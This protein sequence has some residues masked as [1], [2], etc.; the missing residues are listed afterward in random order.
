MEPHSPDQSV[1]LTLDHSCSLK[2]DDSGLE[3]RCEDDSKALQ[4]LVFLKSEMF[5]SFECPS[6]RKFSVLFVQLLDTLNVLSFAHGCMDMSYPGPN[7]EL[8]FEVQDS[9]SGYLMNTY[10]RISSV[11]MPDV[12]DLE[13]YWSEPSSYFLTQ[14]SIMKE[15]VED[16]EWPGGT[17]VEI[18]ME[19]EPQHLSMIA[20]GTGRMTVEM[21]VTDLSGFFC[22]LPEVRHSYK[23]RN[24]RAAFCHLPSGSQKEFSS[25]STKVTVD[26]QGLLKVAHVISVLSTGN[27][28]GGNMPYEG[29]T[30]NSQGASTHASR[31]ATIHFYMQPV[32][33]D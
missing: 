18:V 7:G 15:V 21:P 3:V 30:I 1:K 20:S 22:A 27:H 19:R 5:R 31:A 33:E 32:I 9:H 28:Q 17:T 4:S 24:L 11:E 2:I 29:G 23:Y 12:H 13:E 10:A 26:A 25:I 8:T 16:L 14:G 6:T